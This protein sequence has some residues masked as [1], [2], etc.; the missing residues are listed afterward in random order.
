MAEYQADLQER[1]DDDVLSHTPGEIL[2]SSLTHEDE[3]KG[4]HEAEDRLAH[5]SGHFLDRSDTII[6]A[7]VGICFL[8]AALLALVYT[9]WQFSVAVFIDVPHSFS[10]AQT[11]AVAKA[12]IDMISGLLLVLIIVEILGTVIHYLKA[13]TTS[14]RPFLF[15]GIISATRSILS[16]GAKLSVGTISSGHDFTDAMI[17][18]GVSAA[19]IVA[20]GMTIRLLGKLTE[21]KD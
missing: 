15:I 21:E 9:F 20:L 3:H 5:I 10:D 19:I 18:L 17:E 4:F 6:Y 13:H 2:S 11:T 8:V 14:L 7:V 12:I 16:I 1:E